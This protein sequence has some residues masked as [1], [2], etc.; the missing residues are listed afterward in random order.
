MRSATL[1]PHSETEIVTNPLTEIFWSEAAQGRLVAARCGRCGS[2]RYPPTPYCPECRSDIIEYPALSGQG[3]LFSF[4][5][6]NRARP[7][8]APVYYVPAIVTVP[9]APGIRIVTNVVTD[10]IDALAIDMPLAVRFQAIANG[11]AFPYFIPELA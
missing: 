10:D 5:V 2:F 8:E 7:G 11:L 9:D 6:V 3:E 4:S 1:F